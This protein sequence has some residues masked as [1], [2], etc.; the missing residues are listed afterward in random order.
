MGFRV[1][2]GPSILLNLVIFRTERGP[3]IW[4][5]RPKLQTYI[6]QVSVAVRSTKCHRETFSEKL[7]FQKKNV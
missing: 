5:H 3:S 2:P 6:K 7:I 1:L 4:A